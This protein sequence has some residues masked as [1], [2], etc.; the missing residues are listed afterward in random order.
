MIKSFSKQLGISYKFVGRTLY[1]SGDRNAYYTVKYIPKR[2]GKPRELHAVSGKL[3][4]LQKKGQ[5]VA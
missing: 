4:I 1:G 5:P 3:K 2:N